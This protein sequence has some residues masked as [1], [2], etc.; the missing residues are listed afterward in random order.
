[1]DHEHDRWRSTSEFLASYRAKHVCLLKWTERAGTHWLQHDDPHP[2]KPKEGGC[3]LRPTIRSNHDHR[4][5][6]HEQRPCNWRVH[7]A[8]TRTHRR[9]RAM[10]LLWLPHDD[11]RS[12]K[13]LG[14]I[15]SALRDSN[16]WANG[17]II[18][19]SARSYSLDDHGFLWPWW[20]GWQLS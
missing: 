13:N 18:E 12:N 10:H 15:V 1:M 4:S 7:T 20:P 16:W 5:Q 19:R 17:P 9:P 14:R 3:E 2:K 8:F 6:E 11:H